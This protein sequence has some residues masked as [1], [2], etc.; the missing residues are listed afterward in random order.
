M[1]HL[2]NPISLRLRKYGVWQV[3]WNTFLK[4]DYVYFFF[5]NQLLMQ[6]LN[7][8]INLKCLRKKFIFFEIKYFLKASTLIVFLGFKFIK[9]SK[10]KLKK[11]KLFKQKLSYKFRLNT[12]KLNYINKFN[13]KNLNLY[14]LEYIIYNLS[15]FSLKF[16]NLNKLRKIYFLKI[17]KFSDFSFNSFALFNKYL[18]NKA[19]LLNE[20][21]LNLL[22]FK[23]YI[24]L[25][26]F[27]L[28]TNE[29]LLQLITNS[30]IP[31]LKNSLNLYKF[32]EFLSKGINEFV[33]NCNNNSFVYNLKLIRFLL[34]FEKIKFTAMKF[35]KS[36]LLYYHER[37]KFKTK[38]N[39]YK[40]NINVK[41]TIYL[42]CKLWKKKANNLLIEL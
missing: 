33:I 42:D 32:K 28:Y 35:Y 22:I 6:I 27:K 29:L 7:S 40:L 16:Y 20:K 1:G 19:K 12:L 23:K 21:S 37:F 38:K 11:L 14:I 30:L 3:S 34:K 13:F 17:N 2:I 31:L 15:K 39:K 9:K 26:L 10:L 41:N 4:K 8:I 25:N 36:F 24:F 5:V 18:L